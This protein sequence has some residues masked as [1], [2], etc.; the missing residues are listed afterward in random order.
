MT[1]APTRA[2][3]TVLDPDAAPEDEGVG[4]WQLVRPPS[5]PVSFSVGGAEPPPVVWRVELASAAADGALAETEA[6]AERLDAHLAA[7]PTRVR[8]ALRSRDEA[9]SFSVGRGLESVS[10]LGATEALLFEE[11]ERP[12]SFSVG[13]DREASAGGVS[14]ALERL[15][16]RATRLAR[17][18]TR[19]AGRTVA[20]SDV[21]LLGDVSTVA[22]AAVAPGEVRLHQQALAA[23]LQ[24][25]RA[26]ARIVAQTLQV[27]ALVSTG[28]PL[29]AAP[30]AWRYIRAVMAEVEAL[31][32]AA[33]PTA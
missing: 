23:T 20:T 24:T 14:A 10:P 32:A 13:G 1:A 6:Q 11:L 19:V 5:A 17:I 27:T 26:W 21:T 16:R 2:T 28:N 33:R 9:T 4:P 22:A 25:R 31:E 29:V 18:E 7:V 8:A 12:A 30:A 15:L 3:F